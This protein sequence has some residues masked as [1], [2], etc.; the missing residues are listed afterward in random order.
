[1]AA[2]N[3]TTNAKIAATTFFLV[4]DKRPKNVVSLNGEP[5]QLNNCKDDKDGRKNNM[6]VTNM[7][8]VPTPTVVNK[9]GEHSLN[10][11][12]INSF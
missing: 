9:H 10:N 2:P 3:T 1:M 4:F 12:R 6:S 7:S 8:P 11:V 5:N